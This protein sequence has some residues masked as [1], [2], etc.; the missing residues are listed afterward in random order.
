MP[1]AESGRKPVSGGP[2]VRPGRP[3][4][5]SSSALVGCLDADDVSRYLTHEFV[6]IAQS[7]QPADD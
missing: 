4:S 3:D 7:L 5:W 6:K 2:R 1:V